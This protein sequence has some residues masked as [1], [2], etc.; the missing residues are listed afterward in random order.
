MRGIDY[1]ETGT[2]P[3]VLFVPG[4]YSTHAAWRQIQKLLVPACRMVGTSLC[5]YGTTVETR[6]RDDFDMR[7]EVRIVEEVALRAGGKIHP[8]GHSFGGTVALAAAHG[9]TIDV[10]SVSLFEANP[11]ALLQAQPN[12][13]LHEAIY[14]LSRQFEAAVDERN[15][16]AAGLIIDFWGG[17]GTFAAMPEPVRNY[18]RETASANVLDWRTDFGFD[19]V[20]SHYEALNVP[21]L[22]V[23][24]ALANPAMVAMT[25]ALRQAVPDAYTEVIPG[26][27]HFLITSHASECAAL[28]TAFL[29]EID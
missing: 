18:C 11:F 26:A 5:G 24:G 28:L 20:S 14:A 7:H 23:R 9:G 1:V 8:V 4:S 17:D 27:G 2:G 25:E 3:T 12:E 21:V 29:A 19:A 22:L 13:V 10:A 15:P 16:D 6:T